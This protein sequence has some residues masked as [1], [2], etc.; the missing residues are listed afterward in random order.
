MSEKLL[1]LA[2]SSDAILLLSSADNWHAE[3]MT[4]VVQLLEHK[5]LT[6]K[7]MEILALAVDASDPELA[8]ELMQLLK[9]DTKAN[10]II[11]EYRNI[12]PDSHSKSSPHLIDQADNDSDDSDEDAGVDDSE[13]LGK[14]LEPASCLC[15]QM[16]AQ[17]LDHHITGLD[18]IIK[19]LE[20]CQGNQQFVEEVLM[21]E[22][23][24]KAGSPVEYYQFLA[25]LNGSEVLES[26]IIKHVGSK[27]IKSVTKLIEK[28][29]LLGHTNE[30]FASA[31]D[32]SDAEAIKASSAR[33][34]VFWLK[35]NGWSLRVWL[36]YLVK[37][38]R[39]TSL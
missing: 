5:K 29:L 37:C 10:N 24:K 2:N 15:E 4:T 23:I 19:Y 9:T 39:I 31:S 21:K 6:A 11:N 12:Y 33:Q 22:L 26:V 8:H 32:H 14:S 13:K 35:D 34:C 28:E 38:T 25:S 20:P 18:K 17:F 16:Q 27:D 7:S 30:L 1:A 36:S 3:I